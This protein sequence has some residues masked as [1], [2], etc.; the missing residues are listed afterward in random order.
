MLDKIFIETR[1]WEDTEIAKINIVNQ[2]YYKKHWIIKAK[3]EK[4]KL[5]SHLL[6]YL[7]TKFYE[8]K[9]ILLSS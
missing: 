3:T 8:K 9:Q 7:K 4:T 5:Q 2:N 6:G 1:F